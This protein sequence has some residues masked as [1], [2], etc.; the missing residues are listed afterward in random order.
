MFYIDFPQAVQGGKE[1]PHHR[2]DSIH[3]FTVHPDVSVG[4]YN[5]E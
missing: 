3:S 1:I 2:T 4:F 5:I